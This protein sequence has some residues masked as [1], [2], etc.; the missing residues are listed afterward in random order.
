V[1]PKILKQGQRVVDESKLGPGLMTALSNFP[2]QVGPFDLFA[3]II[4]R[5]G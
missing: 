5:M 4:K 2:S 1:A 3:N